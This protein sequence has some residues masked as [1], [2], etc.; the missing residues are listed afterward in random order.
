M[1]QRQRVTVASDAGWE[2]ESSRTVYW[3]R[4]DDDTTRMLFRVDEPT[5]EAGLKVL[6]I[7]PDRGDPVIYVY[8][9]DTKRARRLVGSGASNSVLGTDFT[10]EDAMHLQSFLHAEN[11]RRV[12]DADIDGHATRVVETTPEMG[13]SAY[14]LIRTYVDVD[15]CL[16]IKTEFLGPSGSLDKTFVAIRDQVQ[17]IQGRWIPLRSV[18]FNHKHKSRTE[19]VLSGVEI[20]VDLKDRLFTVAEIKK[21]H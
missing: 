13:T 9:P 20:D 19:F 11:T 14:S 4:F 21:S 18:M 12:D 17:E 15:Y 7:K 5:S 8:T 3:K 6:V 2:R 1:V 10:Y 16:P